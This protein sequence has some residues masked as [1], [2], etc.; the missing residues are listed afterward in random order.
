MSSL[1]ENM[2]KLKLYREHNIRYSREITQVWNETISSNI[3]NLGKEKHIILEQV[4]IA[5]ID[6]YQLKIAEKCIHELYKE[7]PNSSRIRILESM[8]HEADENFNR[9]LQI[10]NDI[11]KKDIT[12]SA[13]RKRKIAICKALGRNT[14]AIKELV[15]Y[16]KIFMADVEAWQELSELYISE[17]EYSKAAF[18]VEEL[19]LHNPHNHLLH[20]RYADI[21]YSQGGM[22]N[23]ELARTYYN[24][25]YKLNPKNIRALYGSY[26]TTTALLNSQ[27]VSGKKKD[28][29]V[30]VVDW[31]LKE[32]KKRYSEVKVSEIEESLSALEI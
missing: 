3:D 13:A 10:L 12:N 25:S 30:K 15:E 18:C 31:C 9:A 16:L 6:C 26:L 5:A 17:H 22:E 7:F 14:E 20:Q 4:C 11:V 19:I 32:I 23:I 1:K 24:Q 2:E 21:R 8:Y 27:K 29:A 28:A